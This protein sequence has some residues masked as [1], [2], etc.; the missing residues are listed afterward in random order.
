MEAL[1]PFVRMYR[2]IQSQD[3]LINR[4]LPETGQVLVFRIQGQVNYLLGNDKQK[5]PEFVLTG[6]KKS[7]RLINYNQNSA[8]IIVIFKEAGA[9]AFF[10]E[11]LYQIFEESVPL[12]NLIR[13]SE[14]D[15][16]GEQLGL[17]K[18]HI[19]RIAIIEQ[20]LL[21][22]LHKRTSDQ[23]IQAALYKI[24]TTKGLY[25]IKQLASSL[26]ISQDPFE[27]RFRKFVGASP[28]QFSS[29]VRMK[30][31]ISQNHR[32]TSLT[33]MALNAGFFDQSHFNKDFKLFTG[34]TPTD[35][36]KSVPLW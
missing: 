29:I 18:T 21:S 9:S 35:Y 12:E 20:F 10:K 6:L 15:K 36:F 26:Y 2:I 17:A 16:I 3:E 23:L 31:V 13:C 7:V 28:K 5:L 22:R 8:N 30:S 34:L 24:H 32:A 11:P 19:D 27:K 1:R 4:V 25:P 33:E 14:I